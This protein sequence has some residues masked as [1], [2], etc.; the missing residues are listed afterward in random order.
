[1]SAYARAAHAL[2]AEVSGS[3]RADS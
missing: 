2:G 1:M 3:D